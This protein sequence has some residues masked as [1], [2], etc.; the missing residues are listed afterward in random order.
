MIAGPFAATVIRSLLVWG[1]SWPYPSLGNFINL[2]TDSR[3]VSAAANT[4]IAGTF[5]TIFSLILGFSL[6]FLVART[7]MPGRGWLE[8]ANLVPFFLSPYVGA[9]S[10]IWLLAPH[11]GLLPA[12]ARSW[13]GISLEWL[14]IYSVPGVIFVLTLFYTPY[15]YLFVMPPLREMGL[16]ERW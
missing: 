2:F 13:F 8:T 9:I 7:D 11:G 3:F 4:L 16:T 6:A 5:T 12:L 15:V 1:E 10:W 14:N